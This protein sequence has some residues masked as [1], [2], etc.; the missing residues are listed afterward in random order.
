FRVRLRVR[1]REGRIKAIRMNLGPDAY[2]YDPLLP[3]YASN[4]GVDADMAGEDVT[5]L[6]MVPAPIHTT[7][8]MLSEQ[9]AATSFEALESN[10]M[11]LLSRLGD[12]MAAYARHED[13][14]VAGLPE[15]QAERKRLDH[16]A[17]GK[18]V[19]RYREGLKWVAR[20]G[21]LLEAFRMANET[22]ILL[23]S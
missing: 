3:A 9:H 5:E 21:R 22:M 18:E 12:D 11:P 2:R 8:R 15:D 19:D 6:R 14:S 23:N 13:W 20:D 4:C 16:A 17:F 10:P 7:F 1:P